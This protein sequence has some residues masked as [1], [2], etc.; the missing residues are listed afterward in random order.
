[1]AKYIKIK[2]NIGISYSIEQLLED[3]IGAT[4]CHLYSGELSEELLKTYDV[5][6]LIESK[7]PDDQEG[8]IIEEGSPKHVGGVWIQTWIKRKLNTQ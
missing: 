7:K 8:Y 5:Y 3:N 6:P 2:N 1:M 4:V